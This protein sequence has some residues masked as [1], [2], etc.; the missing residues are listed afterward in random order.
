MNSRET[1]SAASDRL[2][3]RRISLFGVLLVAVTV[4]ACA[5]RGKLQFNSD[6][7]PHLSYEGEVFAAEDAL[8]YGTDI[9]IL[10]LTDE[11][12]SFVRDTI[13]SRNNGKTRL[14]S[15]HRSIKSPGNL[16]M[17]Y[18]PFADGDAATT[19]QRGTANCLSYAHMFV[20]LAREAGLNARYQ[21]M[22]V[23]PE[24]QRI[25]E[26]VAVRLHVNVN[27]KTRDG[28][29][30]TVDIDPL[31]RSEVAETR[32]LTDKE[33]LGLYFNNLAMLALA[34]GHP[35]RAW[36]QLILGLEA[37]PETSHLWVNLG[38][39]YRHAGQYREA[40]ESYFTALKLDR[41]DRSA[42]NNLVV[43][44]ELEGREQEQ[45]YW[46]GRLRHY[47][48]QNPFYH[49]NLG[50]L[51]LADEDWD[52]AVGHFA[53][54]HRIR[55]DD[56]QFTYQMGLAEHRRGNDERAVKLIHEAINDTLITAE[57]ARYRVQLR[58]IESRLEAARL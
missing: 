41:S 18:D 11:M 3:L 36:Q 6:Q 10:H 58:T 49:A 37:S 32:L 52:A 2:T 16:G 54:A 50:E 12:R 35:V 20:A 51:A 13:Q 25:G 47:R 5:T 14:M 28:T 38:A 34:D 31:S 7:I 27:V 48:N 1:N 46:L 40:E 57:K 4:G 21:W 33:A 45:E 56:S 39:I 19:F 53:K 29:E 17:Q 26:R 44:Y 55:P 15:L 23:R 30:F 24:W 9:D 8:S 22:E 42:M 43:L